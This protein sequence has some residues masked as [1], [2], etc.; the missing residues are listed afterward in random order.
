MI[1]QDS[2]P[3]WLR[4]ADW[5][6]RHRACRVFEYTLGVERTQ[7]FMWRRLVELEATVAELHSR[8]AELERTQP[9]HDRGAA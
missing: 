8:V 5:V 1:A 3:P 2:R 7:L 4:L 6:Y 9:D